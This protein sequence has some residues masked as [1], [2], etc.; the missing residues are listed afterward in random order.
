MHAGA[1]LD[2]VARRWASNV[3]AL[4]LQSAILLPA[5]VLPAWLRRLIWT[6]SDDSAEGQETIEDSM[7]ALDLAGIG[8]SLPFPILPSSQQRLYGMITLP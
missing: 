4:A 1:G 5:Q 2:P 6:P 3:A 8:Q 7:G